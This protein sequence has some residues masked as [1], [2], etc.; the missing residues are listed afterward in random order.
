MYIRGLEGNLRTT[1]L[2]VGRGAIDL[3]RSPP[4]VAA[5]RTASE[6]ILDLPCSGGR[7][8]RACAKRC[9]SRRYDLR[10]RTRRRKEDIVVEILACSALAGNPE[11]FELEPTEFF[12][13]LDVLRLAAHP[14][15]D[16]SSESS[17]PT[18]DWRLA[19]RHCLT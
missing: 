15:V 9:S 3:M 4:M 6:N 11:E 2:L 1:D 13:F 7:V 17:V 14:S 8:T 10:E 16:A 18:I 5:N 12:D 19:H